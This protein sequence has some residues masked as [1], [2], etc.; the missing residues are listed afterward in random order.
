MLK[1]HKQW[2]ALVTFLAASLLLSAC[3][4]SGVHQYNDEFQNI[5]EV[6]ESQEN[7]DPALQL[8]QSETDSSLAQELEAL[9]HSGQWGDTGHSPSTADEQEAE[10]SVSRFPVVHNKQVAAYLDLFQN[11]QH[12]TFQKWLNRSGRYLSIMEE[13]FKKSGIPTDLVYLSMIESGYRQRAVSTANAV[14]LWQFIRSTG[15]MYDL[16]ID[17]YLDERRDVDKSTAAAASFLA[18]LYQDF[19]D[20]H[21]AVAAYNAGPGKIR[22]GLEK[23]NV[24]NFW[25]LAKTDFLPTET[26]R[27]V[28]KLVA[29]IMIARNP[30]QYGFHRNHYEEPLQYDTV[31]VGPGLGLDAVALISGADTET[32]KEL[33]PELR[34]G[35][36]PANSRA[37]QV[38]IPAGSGNLAAR[39]VTRLQSYAVTDYR[40]HKVKRGESLAS[41][42]K[43]YNIS[44]TTLVK[45]NN[46]HATRLRPG[47]SLR[48]PYSAIRYQLLAEGSQTG[49]ASNE[50]SL[51]LH[52]IA[53]GET[54]Y[55]IARKY[56]VSPKQVL[57]WNDLQ[58]PRLVR[59]GQQLSL[60]I[61]AVGRS[62]ASTDAAS[63]RDGNA[64]QQILAS[65]TKL[66]HQGDG[67]RRTSLPAPFSL[68][69]SDTVTTL[70]AR[71]NKELKP[72]HN[73]VP[74]HI[75]N[76]EDPYD[77]YQVR[78][79][80][81]LWT[82]SRKFNVSTDQ[83]K[84]WNRLSSD[85]LQPGHRLK[86]KKV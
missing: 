22:S 68:A 38:K 45:A 64:T 46:L 78:R 57:A 83:I 16:T 24:D 59:T 69:D 50:K 34:T 41:L 6:A 20:W 40:K 29:A 72:Q 1:I 73:R 18:D 43:K 23:Y 14:G 62:G 31:A 76:P 21:L 81:S 11:K 58:N 4:K 12:T 35:R 10:S 66:R 15:K 48:I 51:I 7:D 36:T 17:K 47:A 39:N 44:R 5:T 27:Y 30:E 25:A 26:K 84:K 42:S 61:E 33:N 74:A 55:G 13:E 32:V 28:P 49:L 71:L 9:S 70:A 2:F 77:W 52:R 67:S 80:D 86:M 85:R 65:T 54:V 79:G 19:G 75:D 56:H 3:S 82:I 60:Y 63:Q 53:K 37:Y 8:E